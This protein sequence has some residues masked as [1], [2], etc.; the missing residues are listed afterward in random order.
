MVS[1][2]WLHRPRRTDLKASH[3]SCAEH[4]IICRRMVF[5]CWLHRSRR[6]D[7]KSLPSILRHSFFDPMN[8]LSLVR[9]HE[10]KENPEEGPLRSSLLP[11]PFLIA[12]IGAWV[13]FS[14][15]LSPFPSL[16]PDAFSDV[17]IGI[18]FRGFCLQKPFISA[19]AI[20][21]ILRVIEGAAKPSRA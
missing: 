1:H 19:T 15:T 11:I 8:K 9:R 13:G 20:A 21:A 4:L 10:Q 7:L 2:C 12:P 17:R 18:T 16:F 5:H 14:I 6:T 3:L